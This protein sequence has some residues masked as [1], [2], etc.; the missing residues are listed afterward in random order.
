VARHDAAKANTAPTGARPDAAETADARPAQPVPARRRSRSTAAPF[1]S[2][3]VDGR[4]TSPALK[5]VRVA[6]DTPVALPVANAADRRDPEVRPIIDGLG[7]AFD[8]PLLLMALALAGVLCVASV[9]LRR[10]G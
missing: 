4:A 10:T 1:V 3:R 2:S 7:A 8:L 9:R 6:D 5:T